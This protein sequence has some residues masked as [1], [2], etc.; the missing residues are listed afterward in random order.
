MANRGSEWRK[1][2]LHVHSCFSVLNNSYPHNDEGK[3]D[4]KS[5]N[6]FIQTLKGNDISAIGLTNYFQFSDDD[7]ELKKQLGKMGIATFLNLE[8]RLSN[9]NKDDELFDYHIIFNNKLD[10][11]IIK[12]LLA[13]LKANIGSTQKSFKQLSKDEIKH[14]AS[15]DFHDLLKI[16][17][18]EGNHVCGNYL[19]GF[20]SRG[21]GSA[22][23]DKDPKNMAIYEEITRKSNFLIHASSELKNLEKDR[24]Y[25]LNHELYPRPLIQSSDA[26]SLEKIGKQY[27]WIKANTTF[28]GLR[29]I[30]FEP[31][32]R[33][34]L[35]IDKPERKNDYQ[36]IDHVKL[37]DD[38]I[39]FLNPNL[40][41]V[42]GGRS[43]GK[44]TLSNSIAKKLHNSG[45]DAKKMHTYHENDDETLKIIWKNGIEDDNREIEFLPQDYMIHLAEHSVER[46]SLIDSI[47]RSKDQGVQYKE[48]SDYNTKVSANKSKI[49]T[50][51]QEYFD[52]KDKLSE[53][54]KPEGDKNGILAE[55]KKLTEEQSKKR[56]ENNFSDDEVRKYDE[57]LEQLAGCE[58]AKKTVENNLEG[59]ENLELS[60][61]SLTK[62]ISKFDKDFAKILAEKLQSIEEKA[63]A[64]WSSIVE[65][66]ARKEKSKKEELETKIREIQESEVFTKGKENIFNNE[67]LKELESKIKIETA[68]L[69]SMKKYENNK[70]DLE[71]EICEKQSDILETYANYAKFREELENKFKIETGKVEIKL[72]FKPEEFL[73]EILNR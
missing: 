37:D 23:S 32:D 14:T 5:I 29:Q 33:I 52:V 15:I 67:S 11:E 2:D 48:I 56:K 57:L 65:E 47:V 54:V 71:K 27:S 58:S 7:F 28:E 64:A 6:Q 35:Q 12:D 72:V 41:T 60:A 31:K 53:L 51:L 50:Q 16:L 66:L 30:L 20:L 61:F 70:K 4:D 45:C 19:L 18:D 46:N 69:E 3:I 38:K 24:S 26:H 9:I 25:W 8:V 73:G 68:N 42:I 55:I 10:D 1:W 43:M 13:N 49:T 63:K 36:V 39:L 59:V 21:H 62:D 34:S 40:N 44:S 22:T 17:E